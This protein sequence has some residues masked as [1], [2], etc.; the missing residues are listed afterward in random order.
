VW[1]LKVQNKQNPMG[2]SKRKQRF[3]AMRLLPSDSAA[4][5]VA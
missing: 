2:I 5:K 1:S 3:F 4:P